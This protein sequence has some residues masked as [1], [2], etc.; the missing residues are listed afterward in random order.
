MYA[1]ERAS[2]CVCV[3]VCV[4]VRSPRIA[5]KKKIHDIFDPEPGLQCH[6]GRIIYHTV[7]KFTKAYPVVMHPCINR[8]SKTD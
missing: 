6:T 7:Y 4:C 1:S 3:C 2:V 5:S 8:L